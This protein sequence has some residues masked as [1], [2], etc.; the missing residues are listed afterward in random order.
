[1]Q[2]LRRERAALLVLLDALESLFKLPDQRSLAGLQT[3]AS[4]HAPEK[5]AIRPLVR[6]V[7]GHQIF[8]RRA[9]HEDDYVGIGGRVHDSSVC[10]ISG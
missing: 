6:V 8:G 7:D 9:R 5:I 10:P 1:M 3:I 2:F 4:H